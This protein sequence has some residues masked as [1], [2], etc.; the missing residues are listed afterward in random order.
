MVLRR[1]GCEQRG[2]RDQRAVVGMHVR[3]ACRL[4][5]RQLGLQQQGARGPRSSWCDG[6]DGRHGVRGVEVE[7]EQRGGVQRA[8]RAAVSLGNVM[9]LTSCAR[10][11][12]CANVSRS[13]NASADSATIMFTQQV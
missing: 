11:W 7:A 12:A 9:Q 8:M 13:L 10:G 4:G 2:R 5:L 6:H 1:C 3:N